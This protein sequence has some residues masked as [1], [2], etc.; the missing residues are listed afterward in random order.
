SLV[1]LVPP[2]NQPF[3]CDDVAFQRVSADVLRISEAGRVDLKSGQAS[4][5]INN[6]DRLSARLYRADMFDK[7]GTV[8]ANACAPLGQFDKNV[9]V[10][11]TGE[12]A[13]HDDL[14]API[15]LSVVIGASA[16]PH[17]PMHIVDASGKAIASAS[18]VY[19]TVGAAGA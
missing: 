8:I 2:A 6:I 10:N 4:A 18:I 13:A 19:T 17:V 11:L 9:A 14:T 5:P 3:T 16:N 1:T 7:N 12:P 15:D